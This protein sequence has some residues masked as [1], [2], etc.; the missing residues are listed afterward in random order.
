MSYYNLLFCCY[1]LFFMAK[2]PLFL[3]GVCAK[4][5]HM[6]MPYFI[7]PLKL[8]LQIVVTKSLRTVLYSSVCT[9]PKLWEEQ[10]MNLVSI[11]RHR[12]QAFFFFQNLHSGPRVTASHSN[13]TQG[14]SS[15]DNAAGTCSYLPISIYLYSFVACIGTALFTFISLYL[16]HEQFGF[17]SIYILTCPLTPHFHLIP[18]SKMRGIFLQ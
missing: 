9:M 2:I 4:P 16:D 12:Q 6:A 10:P 3:S 11:P 18:E 17:L 1:V 8:F 14:F 15:R 13:D 7:I 5:T